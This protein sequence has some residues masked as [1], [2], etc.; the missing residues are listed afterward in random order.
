MDAY[1]A[2]MYDDMAELNGRGMTIDVAGDVA[3][4]YWH[5]LDESVSDMWHGIWQI[6][7]C[8]MA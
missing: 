8:H 1:V 5:I 2:C 7:R 6:M 3:F 4:I